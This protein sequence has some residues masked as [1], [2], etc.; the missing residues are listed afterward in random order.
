MLEI[1]PQVHGRHAAAADLA[2]DAV[3]IRDCL[4]KT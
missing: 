4:C 3:P 2:V 1:V